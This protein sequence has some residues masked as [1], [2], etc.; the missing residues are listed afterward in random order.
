MKKSGFT[1][2]EILLALLIISIGIV[3]IIGLLTSTLGAGSKARDD[4]HI[5]SFADMVLNQ[6]HTK[7]WTSLSAGSIAVTDYD[8]Q[9]LTMTLGTQSQYT[10]PI[11][12][13]DENSR[14]RFAMTYQLD[15]AVGDEF[16]EVTLLVWPGYSTAGEP[17][18]F[19][20]EIYNW[21]KVP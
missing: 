3:S 20:T 9:I 1:L 15:L 12:G 4:L 7:D 16:I 2:M 8:E 11:R 18:I 5:V 6:L 19:Q 13:K 14:D 17:K 10:L 21:S